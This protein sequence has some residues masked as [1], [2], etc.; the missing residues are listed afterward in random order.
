M[1]N[2][3]H[4]GPPPHIVLMQLV[5]GFMVS[6]ALQAVAELGIADLLDESPKT[7]EKLAE[8]TSTHASSLYRLL[9][10]L[11]SRGI[12][13]EDEHGCFD[14]TPLSDPLR[15]NAPV[16][17]RDF[18]IYGLHDGNMFA[19][20]RLMEV[21]KTGK[22][23]FKDATGFDF[24][25]YIFQEHP[26]IGERFNRAMTSFAAGMIKMVL[27]TYNFSPFKSIADIG[28]G[29]GLLLV[30]ILKAHP[31]LHGILFELPS[32]AEEAN[33]YL[34]N[35]GLSDRCE[36][37]AGDAFK[38][39]PAGHDAYVLKHVLH[40]WSDEKACHILQRCREAIPEHG[41]LIVLDAVM[42]PDN[43][44]HPA[45]WFD[46]HMMVAL[47]GRERT[48]KEFK[49]LLNRTGFKLTM[50]KPLPASIGIVE[51]VPI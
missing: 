15:S 6:K 2:Q 5:Q 20:T 31:Q 47:G 4:S 30:S 40:D 1:N 44:P 38:T 10:A 22:P 23:S 49:E 14:N 32:V 18:V 8:A 51:G 35:Q 48:E 11:A 50:A 21:L 41:K 39:M 12:F 43:D 24:W 46:L 19:W 25:A 37:I 16:S 27:D 17:V 34:Q 36:I 7:S 29:Q 26:E 9:R 45:K 42:T 3:Q 33:A 28:G 13:R